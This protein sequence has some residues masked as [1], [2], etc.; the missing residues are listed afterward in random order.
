MEKKLLFLVFFAFCSA[1]NAQVDSP[2]KRITNGN[3][4]LERNG[5]KSNV[6][7]ELLFALDEIA[8]KESLIRLQDKGAKANKIEIT[9]PNKKGVLETFLVWES[10]NF[11]SGLQAKYPNI[12][13]YKGIGVTDRTASLYFSFS[14]S[15]IQTMILRGDSGTEFIEPYSKK[16]KTYVLFGSDDRAKGSLPFSC[17]TEDVVLNKQLLAKTAKITANNKVLKTLKLALSCTGEY[18][19]YHGGTTAGALAAM[20]ATMARVNGVFNRDLAVQLTIIAN[21]NLVIYTDAAADPYSDADVGVDGDWNLELQ[22]TLTNVIGNA[23]YDIG[24]LFGA[25]GG[26]GNAGCIGCVCV[27]PS[28]GE[29][30]AKGSAFTSPSDGRPEGDTFDIDFVAHELGHQLGANHTFSYAI[31]DDGVNVEP[32]SGSTIMGYAGITNYDVQ[33]NSDDYFAYASIMQIQDNLATKSCPVNTLLTNNP[34]TI[35][36]GLDYTIPIGTAFVLKGTG[37][38]IDGNAVAYCWEQNDTAVNKLNPAP[39]VR[40]D[41]GFSIASPTKVNGPNFR[42]IKPSSSPIRYMPAYK[43]VLAGRLSTTWESVSTI[44][45]TLNFSLTGRDN[46]L[47]AGQTNTDLMAVTVSAAAGPFTVSSQNVENTNWVQGTSQSITWNVNNT[48]VLAGS[49]NVNIKLSTD[50]GETFAVVL[51]AN[52]P[53]DGSETITVPN[54]AATNCRILIEPTANI[55]YAVNTKPFTI[56]YSVSSVCDTYTFSTPIAIPDGPTTYTERT[57][58]VPATTASISDVNFA[59]N[60]VHSYLSDVQVEVLSPQG[61]TVKLFEKSCVGIN[62][63]LIL[64]Y[65]DLGA[66]LSCGT[67]TA[68]T[69]APF[70]SLAAFN[71]QNPQ[72]VWTLRVRDD[73]SGR[74]G[75]VNSATVTICTQIFVLDTLDFKINDFM[76]YPNPN[77]GDF[78]IQFTNVSSTNVQV[79]VHDLLGRKVY[80]KEFDNKL[81]FN[82]TIHL[83]NVQSG[84]YLITVAAGKREIVR[85]IVVE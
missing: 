55:Y 82:E 28:P 42:S 51:A 48:N 12:R 34:P 46:V 10:S 63:N 9:I 67:T 54:V 37:S 39:V 27:N 26:G 15:G 35:N 74:N 62:G 65:D 16:D 77:K 83:K 38:D 52:T 76:L 47:G 4:V 33:A 29:P 57:I 66:V 24:H 22:T 32:G 5:V 75:T 78:N 50:G 70:E 56:G 14:P 49:S 58:T 21:N 84:V 11:D 31:E 1:I 79:L 43:D 81:N 68:Q 25:T 72:G 64:N 18:A 69:V 73:D 3:T 41:G 30:A 13:A 40:E 85:K 7:S 19:V 2:W 6:E 36:A 8:F 80:E 59:L 60:L 61:K 53:N 23:N 71:G 44:E 17:K 20:N 45:R